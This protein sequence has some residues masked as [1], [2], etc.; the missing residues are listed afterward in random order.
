MEKQ[1][2]DEVGY[3]IRTMRAEDCEQVREICDSCVG[4]GFYSA[5]E[6][7]QLLK[8]KITFLI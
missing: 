5:K 7:S 8:Q 6:L 3:V 1:I 4:K 2:V